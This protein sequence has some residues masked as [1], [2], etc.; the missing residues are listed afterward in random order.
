[1]NKVKGFILLLVTLSLFAFSVPIIY[2]WFFGSSF[3]NEIDVSS[4][5]INISTTKLENVSNAAPGD[6]FCLNENDQGVIVNKGSEKAIVEMSFI[7]AISANLKT[8]PTEALKTD[9]VSVNHKWY[10]KNTRL[11]EVID[12]SVE[13]DKWVKIGDNYYVVIPPKSEVSID[14]I[15]VSLFGEL[16][17]GSKKNGNTTVIRDF[18]QGVVFSLQ[19]KTT[20]IQATKVA[21][22]QYFGNKVVNSIPSLWFK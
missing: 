21:A 2:A 1:M 16:G 12:V 3:T 19:Y 15:Y 17:G 11:N 20:A 8:E 22:E 7:N 13:L 4:A 5:D 14:K 6:K 18:E 9:Y 10:M